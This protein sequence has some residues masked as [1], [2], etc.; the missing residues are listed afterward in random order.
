MLI[1]TIKTNSGKEI[2]LSENDF[3]MDLTTMVLKEKRVYVICKNQ[4]KRLQLVK[5]VLNTDLDN[6][7][8]EKNIE[9]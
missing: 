8:K 7:L 1:A 5:K 3:P 9:K 4:N 6:D 2:M